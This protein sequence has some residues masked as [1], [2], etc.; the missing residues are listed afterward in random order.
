MTRGQCPSLVKVM[1]AV[2]VLC[3]VVVDEVSAT[4]WSANYCY[5]NPQNCKR[6]LS[7]KPLKVRYYVFV[8]KGESRYRIC[9]VSWPKVCYIK[10]LFVLELFLIHQAS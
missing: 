3:L 7:Q 2:M 6:M 9:S 4:L 1:F 8:N 5:L 10:K